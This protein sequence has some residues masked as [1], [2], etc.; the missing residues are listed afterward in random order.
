VHVVASASSSY[1]ITYMIVYDN[2]QQIYGAAVSSM[3]Q[4]LSMPAGSNYVVVQA[5]D[6]TGAVFKSAMTI[7]VSGTSSTT[8]TTSSVGTTIGNIDQ[9]T[10]WQSCTVCAGINA[11][12]P[13]A[14]YSLAQFQGSPSMDGQSAK[15]YIGG[16]T[17]YADALWWKQLGAQPAAKNFVYDLYFYVTNPNAPQALE[18]DINQSVGGYKYIF[19]TECDYRNTHQWK[20]WSG[21]GKTWQTTGI[22]CNP[23]QAYTWNHLTIEVT[24]P[25]TN[26]AKFVSITLN[27]V[28]SYVNRTYYQIPSGASEMNVA[29]QMDG[30][31]AQQAY[32]VW[33]DKVSLRY[34]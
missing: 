12:G 10:G 34:W 25:A 20:V 26:Q 22:A 2:S 15:F 27:G 32:N 11:T 5:W 23:P 19:G 4:Y 7:N 3:N 17:P 8:T 24:R 31:Y 29:F 9:L 16:S 14:A 33:L 18:F 30:N 6:S 21:S 1:P 28:K 13:V